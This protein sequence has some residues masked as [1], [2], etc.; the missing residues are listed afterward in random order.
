MWQPHRQPVADGVEEKK[1]KK[2]KLEC[3]RANPRHVALVSI[4][5]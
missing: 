4:A 2:K 5:T 3:T 1:K